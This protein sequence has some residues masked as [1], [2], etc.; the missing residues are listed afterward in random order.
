ML[1]T[2]IAAF[3]AVTLGSMV[4][5]GE[6][7]F[8]PADLVIST[9]GLEPVAGTPCDTINDECLS[10]QIITAVETPELLA[11]LRKNDGQTPRGS[12]VLDAL[13]KGEAAIPKPIDGYWCVWFYKEA[14]NTYELP[15]DLIHTT[16]FMTTSSG[17]VRD[18]EFMKGDCPT[19]TNAVGYGDP[20]FKIWAPAGPV[21]TAL[22]IPKAM[23]DKLLVAF[24]CS[25]DG[26]I[27]FPNRITSDEGLRID[28]PLIEKGWEHA[29]YG[30]LRAKEK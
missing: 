8:A 13:N 12:V 18:A 27:I 2:L 22:N 3:L 23:R 21:G 14:L 6:P 29:M 16:S 26:T 4:H 10:L 20:D 15:W 7:K 28:I 24:W 5:A 9:E 1:K 30:V 25:E 11:E 19:I 17:I